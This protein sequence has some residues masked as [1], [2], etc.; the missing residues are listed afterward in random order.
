MAHRYGDIISLGRHKVACG[1]CT[2][3]DI[4]R[5][6]FA[7]EKVATIVFSP[8][9]LDRRK[10][11]HGQTNDGAHLFVLG[12]DVP[13]VEDIQVFCIAGNLHIDGEQSTYYEKWI[14]A[15][16]RA[17][18]RRF[19]TY[20]WDKQHGL[21][22]RWNGRLA[23]C[24][25]WIFHLNKYS[26]EPLRFRETIGGKRKHPRNYTL[27]NGNTLSRKSDTRIYVTHDYKIDDSIIRINPS[28]KSRYSGHPAVFPVE[29]PQRLLQ[30]YRSNNGVVYDP[31]CGSGTT[32]LSAD[33]L[34]LTAYGC[35]LSPDYCSVA[36]ER[37][38]KHQE[39]SRKTQS[40]LQTPLTKRKRL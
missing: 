37:W 4:K 12:I 15:A 20:I 18:W 6:L 33:N 34:G 38:R 5:R 17:G 40:F 9:Y 19:S 14:E 39:N 1:D 13:A 27:G 2:D 16:R 21:P 29:L 25:E 35:E 3:P 11:A 36:V 10:Y 28:G 8:P 22:G 26:R 30:S 24:F 32:I 7:T 23:P 31:T